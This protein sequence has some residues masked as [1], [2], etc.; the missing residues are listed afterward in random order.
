[1]FFSLSPKL[2]HLPF[3]FQRLVLGLL[4]ET[5]LSLK[6]SNAKTREAAFGLLVSLAEVQDDVGTFIRS[7]TAAIGSKTSHMR[8]AAVVALSKLVFEYSHD[9][10]VQ[11]LLP[12]LLR[13]V[14]VLSDDPSREVAKSFVGFVRV[15]VVVIPVEQ[16]RPLLP[17]ILQGLLKYHRGKD[18]FRSK[19][20]IIIKKLVK[21]F[22]YEALIPIIPQSESRLLTHMKKL[23]EREARRKAARYD[24]RK[25]E[26]FEFDD[27]IASDEE[28]SDDGRTLFTGATGMSRM[29][30]QSHRTGKRQRSLVHE[31]GGKSAA[32]THHSKAGV[33]LRIRN[34]LDGTKLDVGELTK[35]KVRFSESE[36]LDSDSESPI[37]FDSSGKLVIMEDIEDDDNFGNVAEKKSI[38]NGKARKHAHRKINIPNSKDTERIQKRKSSQ[39]LGSSYK[40]KSAGGDVKKKG[41]KYDPYAYLPLDGRSY[42]KKNRGRA[43]EQMSSVLQRGRKRQK[44]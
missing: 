30:K 15:T 4:A 36:S 1:M 43:V 28:D 13:T 3:S 25:S 5:L 9:D 40:A 7:I 10:I 26:S 21:L 27:M 2:S 31:K 37:R 8:S 44:R 39:K 42:T 12:S 23:S 29:T 20:K 34:D 32:F 19:I 22:G 18:R 16:L 35:R 38:L 6:D 17:D 24:E 41:Q 33:S 11:S 14:L